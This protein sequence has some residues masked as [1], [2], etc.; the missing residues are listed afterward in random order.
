MPDEIDKLIE[1]SKEKN[2]NISRC[3][4]LRK[5]LDIGLGFCSEAVA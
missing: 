5:A 4:I 2:L 1:E 3:D